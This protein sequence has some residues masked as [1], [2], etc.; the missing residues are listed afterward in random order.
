M[1]R[2]ARAF[3]ALSVDHNAT[4]QHT[5]TVLDDIIA[6][7]MG[8]EAAISRVQLLSGADTFA[9]C[10]CWLVGSVQPDCHGCQRAPTP[11]ELQA[12]MRS[13]WDF[14]HAYIQKMSFFVSLETHM[15]H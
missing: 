5:E 6:E 12:P 11:C 13:Q 14:S 3:R 7:F 1:A 2:L 15:T 9:T 4:T 10:F 8:T